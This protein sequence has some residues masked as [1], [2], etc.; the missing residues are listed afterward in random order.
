MRQAFL[1]TDN[2]TVVNHMRKTVNKY[3]HLRELQ[4]WYENTHHVSLVWKENKDGSRVVEGVEATLSKI[5][6]T[7]Q[8]KGDLKGH[9]RKPE[10][11]VYR[12]CRSNTEV[13]DSLRSFEWHPQPVPG[14]R[15]QHT[16]TPHVN[17]FVKDG[18]AY[19]SMPVEDVDDAIWQEITENEFRT[20][21]EP[22][23]ATTTEEARSL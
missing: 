8:G 10:N 11:G 5:T 4:S 22:F 9:W 2:Q 12:P 1:T 7:I 16:Y 15:S 14:I 17:L 6:L 13:W 20:I 3:D 18:R 23:D 21:M 19:L